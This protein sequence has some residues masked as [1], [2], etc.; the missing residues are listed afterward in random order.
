MIG[1]ANPLQGGMN[2]TSSPATQTGMMPP[3]PAPAPAPAPAANPLPQQQFNVGFTPG[4]TLPQQAAPQ[5]QAN[6]L[7]GSYANPVAMQ[8]IQNL[9]QPPAA[10]PATSRREG[11]RGRCRG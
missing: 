11:T 5:A 7:G 2:V 4:M 8:Y 9:L 10:P 6:G 1:L 3:T